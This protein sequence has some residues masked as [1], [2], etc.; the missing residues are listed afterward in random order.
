MKQ[1]KRKESKMS[2]TVHEIYDVIWIIK[3]T[4]VKISPMQCFNH[5]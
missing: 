3:N 1:S 5:K 4:I 2:F